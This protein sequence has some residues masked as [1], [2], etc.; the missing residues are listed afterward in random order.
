MKYDHLV[1]EGA[2]FAGLAY[3]GAFKK[4]EQLGVLQD[5]KYF[6]GPSSGAIL[7]A[8]L[9]FGF[10]PNEIQIIF[11][12]YDFKSV[13][14]TNRLKQ[15]W[16]LLRHWG[17]YDTVPVI[18]ALKDIIRTKIDPEITF[19]KLL[20]QTGHYLVI[21]VSS[22]NAKH[23]L[24]LNPD[25]YP[26]V[27]VI[28]AIQASISIPGFFKAREYDFT[29]KS[30]MYIDGGL[31]D[32]FPS[33]IFT[34]EH[35]I[36]SV[37]NVHIAQN[38]L[39]IKIVHT[40]EMTYQDSPTTLIEYI[41]ALAEL[42]MRQLEHVVINESYTKQTIQL[43]IPDNISSTDLIFQKKIVRNYT[44]SEAKQQNPIL[45]DVFYFIIYA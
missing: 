9:T 11:E 20:E 16:N 3:I 28:D 35:D 44:K 37:R 7:L 27:K 39:G 41:P 13:F 33:W 22:I 34:E 10:S 4:L 40:N 42:M 38:T 32:N 19:G 5:I 45:Y 8:F 31:L 15:I 18:N 36:K 14:K 2:G 30:E 12:T 1:L 6:A 43:M 17:L 26:D 21:V 25:E 23:P 29:G 24:Y